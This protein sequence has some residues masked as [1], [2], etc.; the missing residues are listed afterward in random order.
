MVKANLFST[1]WIKVYSCRSVTRAFV[2]TKSWARFLYRLFWWW[3]TSLITID[4]PRFF[5]GGRRAI[6]IYG[7]LITDRR[8]R[9]GDVEDS[10]SPY[11]GPIR[12]DG[13]AT[14]PQFIDID[15]LRT[16]R[17]EAMALFS[18]GSQTTEVH[19]GSHIQVVEPLVACPT[20][21]TIAFDD[22]LVELA[23]QFFS[24]VP[25]VVS[26]NLR[27]S[28]PYTGPTSGVNL[29]HQD[30][31]SPGQSF[32]CF[33][34]L[35]DV[36]SFN[37]PLSYVMGSHQK[38]PRNWS[39]ELRWA[40]NTIEK[41]YGKEKIRVMTGSVGDLIIGDMRGFHK[42]ERILSGS[43]LMFTINYLIH[44]EMDGLFSELPRT[45][46]REA[47]VEA[48]SDAKRPVADFLIRV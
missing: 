41:I 14:L 6:K 26:S 22:R 12:R 2:V 29:F 21:A 31:N 30:F 43:R 18:E 16:L 34:Y 7:G 8:V 44:P 11:L 36:E 24:C 10:E 25:A 47:D 48:L 46:I 33:L 23:S 1:W 35:T 17:D 45:C 3:D 19:N 13:I 5:P 32:K 39:R 38:L 28:L 37:G 27:L 40:D 9:L 15:L 4:D 20:A 42:G